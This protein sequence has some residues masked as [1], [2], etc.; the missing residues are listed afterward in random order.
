MTAHRYLIVNADDFGQSPGVNRGVIEV[1][2]HGIVTSA[3]LMVRWPSAAA[4]AAYGRVR[5]DLSLGLHFDLGEWAWRNGAW[6]R[7]YEVIS[8]DDVTAVRSELTRQVAAFRQLVGRDPTH[9]DSHQHV[10]EQEPVRTIAIEQA[11][12]LRVPL[13]N[14][15]AEVRYCPDFYGQ[16]ADGSPLPRNITVDRLI[17]ILA[18][19]P[20]GITELGCHPGEGNDLDTMYLTERTQEVKTLSDARVRAA[21]HDEGIKLISFGDIEALL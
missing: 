21:V 14:Y 8:T 1:H 9:I 15:S 2:E 12:S 10:H 6:V 17:E 11:A 20:P 3:S 16:T 5:P 19:L 13:R 4:A 18:A 7:I